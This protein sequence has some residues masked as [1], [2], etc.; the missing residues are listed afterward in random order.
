MEKAGN[1]AGKAAQAHV[2]LRGRLG[3]LGPAAFLSD[4]YFNMQD[5]DDLGTALVKA[6]AHGIAA[7]MFPVAYTTVMLAPVAY[8]V[9]KAGVQWWRKRDAMFQNLYQRGEV[10]GGYVDTQQALT[11]RQAAV[12][13]IQGSKLNARSALG[14]EARILSTGWFR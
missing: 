2:P 8:D 7:A 13:A 3:F 5:G 6:S 4:V 14:G 10:G 11:M 9:A 1:A 12:Q